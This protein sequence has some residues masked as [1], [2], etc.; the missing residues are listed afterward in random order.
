MDGV[1]DI[2]LLCCHED[3]WDPF[4]KYK[5]SIHPHVICNEGKECAEGSLEGFGT[6]LGCVLWVAEFSFGKILKG[7][8]RN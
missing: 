8:E 3:A 2:L 4:G 1:S 7:K 5:S 6:E